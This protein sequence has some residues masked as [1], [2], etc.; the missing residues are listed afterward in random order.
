[1]YLALITGSLSIAQSVYSEQTLNLTVDEVIRTTIS[2]NTAIEAESYTPGISEADI[3]V[4]K[5]EFDP[6]FNLELNE[7]YDRQKQSLEVLST[8]QGQ[9]NYNASLT[10]KATTGTEYE[11]KWQNY[12]YHGNS[13]YLSMYSYFS[14]GLSLTLKQPL[15]KGFLGLGIQLTN[16]NVAKNTFQMSKYAYDAAVVKKAADAAKGY[17]EL[18]TTRK[19]IEAATIA[20]ALAQKTRDEVAARI[21]SGMAAPVDI[22]T[23]EAE[24][25]VREEALLLA[26]KNAVNAENTLKGI[27]NVN[28]LNTRIETVSK[29]PSPAEPPTLRRGLLTPFESIVDQAL[30][31]RQD[32]QQTLIDKKNKDLLVR[33]YK[34]QQLPDLSAVAS[35]GQIGLDSSFNHTMDELTSGNYF[36]W[37]AGLLLNIPIFNWKNRGNRIKAEL[38]ARQID[39]TLREIKKTIEV[40]AAEA[41][42]NLNYGIKKIKASGKS[43]IAAEK[44]LEAQDGMFKAGLT[45]LNDL[46]TFQRDYATAVYDEARARAEYAKYLVELNR[47]QGLLP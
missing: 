39:A 29:P 13:P 20:L 6:S 36:S 19:A 10:G 9:I 30:K 41:Y 17:W 15:L 46:L 1:M 32:Y 5:G 33:Y 43:L 40:E 31:V 14:S 34:N 42:N 12:K 28:L 8:A 11:L 27:M 21:A 7:T 23:A 24:V 22:Y 4:K 38:E 47:I 16:L 2:Q 26:E 37:K 3:M 45:T 35:Y 18:T 44:K 25:A